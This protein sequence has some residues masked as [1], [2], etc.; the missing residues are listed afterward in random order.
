MTAMKEGIRCEMCEETDCVFVWITPSEDYI[1]FCYNCDSFG[2]MNVDF[3]DMVQCVKC[4]DFLEKYEY[5]D[6]CCYSCT[7]CNSI[8]TV[9]E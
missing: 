1:G 6:H 5:A 2:E 8:I 4:S 9:E 7:E 3:K